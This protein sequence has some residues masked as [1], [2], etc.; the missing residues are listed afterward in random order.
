MFLRRVIV[1]KPP[2]NSAR[3]IFSTDHEVACVG[4][5]TFSSLEKVE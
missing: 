3:G 5:R 1:S 2:S 4:R